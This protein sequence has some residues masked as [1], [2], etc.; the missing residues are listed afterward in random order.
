M[1]ALGKATTDVI[2]HLRGD[3]L[4]ARSSR[5]MATLAVGTVTER[6]LRL[7]RNMILT[8]LLVPGQ[9]G[10]MAIVVA[11]SMALEALAEVGVKQS[12][13]HHKKGGESEYLNV[14]WWFQVVRG[15]GLF[16]IAYF[17]TPWI[18]NFYKHPELL[19][20]MRL[21]FTSILF[22]SLLSPRAY[23]LEKKIQFGR[24]VFLY[25]GSALFGTLVSLVLAYFI[26]QNVWAL[27]IGFVAEAVVRCL[28]SFVLCPFLPG[29][30]IDRNSLRE[31][32]KFARRMLG[33]AFLTII[34]RQTDIMVLGRLVSEE[35][36]GLYYMA[37]QL[38]YQPVQLFERIVGKVLLPAFAEKQEEKESIC[39]AVTAIAKT[40][41]VFGIPVLSFVIICARP[42]LSLVYGSP[43][44]AV[45]V[46]FSFLCLWALVTTQA[47]VVSSI[48]IGTGMPHLHRR[49]V[50]LRAAILIG[51]IYPAIR[52]WGLSGAAATVFVAYSVALIPPFLWMRRLINLKLNEYALSW[53]PGFWASLVVIVPTIL[54]RYS[55]GT[56]Y[57]LS[58]IVGIISCLGAWL[59]GLL[60][61]K[62]SRLKR[63]CIAHSI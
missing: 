17:F 19:P 43:Y 45:P 53:L 21:A 6:A 56:K 4:K 16:G 31:L 47:I 39:R 50:T 18:S 28:L 52:L 14:A 22:N 60:L 42:I 26:I 58:M 29:F 20:L 2:S 3:S 59:V 46:A 62:H 44:G 55:S 35:Q 23:V 8:R 7:V 12:I 57:T 10:L 63:P 36:L 34:V 49:A 11:A 51:L 13:I 32:L 41:A 1:G 25:Q 5:G 48:L 27:V 61:L 33:L 9:F 40:T 24:W 38:A 30:R 37:L 54:L 15:L